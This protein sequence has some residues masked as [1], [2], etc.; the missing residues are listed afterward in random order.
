MEI[1][2]AIVLQ[3]ENIFFNV[4]RATMKEISVTSRLLR[5]HP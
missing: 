2:G 4:D 3:V 1:T 5:L